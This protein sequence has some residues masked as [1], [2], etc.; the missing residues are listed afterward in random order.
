MGV[1]RVE[2]GLLGREPYSCSCLMFV[3]TGIGC[4]I[5]VFYTLA[6]DYQELL[7]FETEYSSLRSHKLTKISM[8]LTHYSYKSNLTGRHKAV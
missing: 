3:N 8:L 7:L 5:G 6:Y 2:R 1:W 4:H